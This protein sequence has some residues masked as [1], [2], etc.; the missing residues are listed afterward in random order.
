[1]FSF[2]VFIT[3]LIS[4]L[5][6]YFTLYFTLKKEITDL[7]STSEK[8]KEIYLKIENRK[9]IKKL[10]RNTTI[11]LIISIIILYRLPF[12]V[13]MLNDNKLINFSGIGDF[14]L[15]FLPFKE[16][17]FSNSNFKFSF[18]T[19]IILATTVEFILYIL[20]S[21]T[22]SSTSIPK[23][24]LKKLILIAFAFALIW[25]NNY[26]SLFWTYCII[27]YFE[28]LSIILNII[29]YALIVITSFLISCF[30]DD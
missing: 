13:T 1:M 2:S 30:F 18:I 25:L 29:L 3:L 8:S 10:I 5:S 26:A 14:F 6:F 4:I 9:R 21:V 12:I 24:I 15:K 28:L 7:S 22:T 27:H 17:F 20:I 16:G 23:S 19:G 11:S